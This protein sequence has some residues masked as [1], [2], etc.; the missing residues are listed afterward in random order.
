MYKSPSLFRDG[1]FFSEFTAEFKRCTRALLCTRYPERMIAL[2]EKLMEI[3]ERAEKELSE[4]RD[5]TELENFRVQVP[6]KKGDRKST[7]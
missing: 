5:A 1:D 3:R 7:R 4:L 2:K 6:G